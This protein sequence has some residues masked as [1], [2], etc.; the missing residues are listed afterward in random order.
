MG[1]SRMS[2]WYDRRRNTQF[3][4]CKKKNKD[5][6][7]ETK[8]DNQHNKHNNNEPNVDSAAHVSTFRE[9]GLDPRARDASS[10]EHAARNLGEFDKRNEK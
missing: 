8:K 6:T 1:H 2:R 4:R 5:I 7:K 3:S 10:I 9:R